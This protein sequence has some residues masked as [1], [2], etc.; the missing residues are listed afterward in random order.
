MSWYSLVFDPKNKALQT[1]KND[2]CTF[3]YRGS[4]CT[5]EHCTQRCYLPA[6]DAYKYWALFLGNPSIDYVSLQDNISK[7]PVM[8]RFGVYLRLAKDSSVACRELPEPEMFGSDSELSECIIALCRESDVV[9]EQVFNIFKGL[10]RAWHIEKKLLIIIFEL[11]KMHGSD[12]LGV[13]RIVLHLIANRGLD[14]LFDAEFE[15]RYS[16]P[17]V[18]NKDSDEENKEPAG[19]IID[20]TIMKKGSEN[21]EHFLSETK[22]KENASISQYTVFQVLRLMSTTEIDAF[23][24]A[25]DMVL[26]LKTDYESL[27]RRAAEISKFTEPADIITVLKNKANNVYYKN[28]AEVE[29]AQEITVAERTSYFDYLVV[30][31]AMIKAQENL[32]RLLNE[33]IAI[34]EDENIALKDENE[35]LKASLSK[36]KDEISKE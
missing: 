16:N 33:K 29:D 12:A 6:A 15:K 22:S 11:M 8:L 13:Y 1:A 9:P 23:T 7:M 26:S 3:K 4:L 28:C 14:L 17:D 31:H 24:N 5:R 19:I 25:T 20:I 30:Q 27:I 34:I 21:A 2:S 36:I 10:E 32:K 18:S 35:K